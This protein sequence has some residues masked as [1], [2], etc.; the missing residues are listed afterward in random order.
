MIIKDQ[1]TILSLDLSPGTPPKA[2][3]TLAKSYASLTL[4]PT[5]NSTPSFVPSFFIS[6]ISSLSSF[7]NQ[8]NVT[9]SMKHFL[10]LTNLSA[11][12]W[13]N[14]I[15]IQRHIKLYIKIVWNI[16]CYTGICYYTHEILFSQLHCDFLESNDQTLF[17][18]KSTVLSKVPESQ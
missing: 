7:K 16:Y 8:F 2:T 15:L 12:S 9:C 14:C 1:I 3:R 5:G 18:L 13:L 4:K 6:G 17:I 10:S 11:F